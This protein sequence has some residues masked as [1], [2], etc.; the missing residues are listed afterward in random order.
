MQKRPFEQP[1]RLT[2]PS[3]ESPTW[4]GQPK[5][6]YW[7]EEIQ[8]GSIK[9][10]IDLQN[11]DHFFVGSLKSLVDVHIDYRY[12][13]RKHAVLQF[14]EDGRIFLMDLSSTFGTLKNKK[15]INPNEFVEVQVGDQF[16]FGEKETTVRTYVLCGLDPNEEIESKEDDTP[17]SES[18]SSESV[19]K[20]DLMDDEGEIEEE[21]PFVS[22]IDAE[23]FNTSIFFDE[24]DDFF[25]RTS[26]K[27]K[28]K[29]TEESTN[30]S[31]VDTVETLSIKIKSLE[32]HVAST[33][34]ALNA[35]RS[36]GLPTSSST[37]QDS[38]NEE[39]ID[40]L[41]AF[42][43]ENQ[44]SIERDEQLNLQKKLKEAED[45]LELNRKYLR[46]VRGST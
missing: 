19:D 29:S 15:E 46:I 7:L 32:Q 1:R 16:N 25:D 30:D 39:E 42:M 17:L 12:V 9:R 3:Y 6:R 38:S 21:E 34:D 37:R 22:Q 18:D 28:L 2:P 20:K 45:L 23:E 11:A 5:S 40:P 24:N 4:K 43:N 27:A 41:D 35:L 36:K 26:K 14:H 33:K 13:S 44:K 31:N 8:N 10:K